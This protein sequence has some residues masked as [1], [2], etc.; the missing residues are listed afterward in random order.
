MLTYS[1]NYK[2]KKIPYIFDPGQSIPALSADG[3]VDMLTGSRCSYP[4][5]MSWK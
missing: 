2:E 1:V 3:M 4:M 5:T